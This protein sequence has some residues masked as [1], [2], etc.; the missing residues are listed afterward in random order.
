MKKQLQTLLE[1]TGISLPPIGV[2]DVDDPASF[3]PFSEP[4]HCIFSDFDAWREGK[5]TMISNENAASFECPGAGYWLRGI[6]AMPREAVAGYLAGQEGLKA[7]P[8]IKEDW[9]EAHPPYLPENKAVVISQLM[10]APGL[11]HYEA[12][13]TVTF[14]VR[15][16]QLS[17]L[18]TGAEYFNAS[19][20][21]QPVT[22]VYGSGCGQILSLFENFDTPKA[23]IGATDIAVRKY[24]P[25]DILAFTVTKPMLEQLC[26]LD[27]NC[28]LHKTFWNDLKEARSVTGDR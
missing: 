10:S 20:D 5:S 3:A 17:L 16:D 7:S 22:A 14:F 27:E 24:L 13:K 25:A 8:G 28:F 18:I 9:L 26:N 21:H 23:M 2:Y 15:P 6:Q 11:E 19:P 12:L 1:T 4:N